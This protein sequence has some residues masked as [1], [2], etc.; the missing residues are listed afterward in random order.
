MSFRVTS[1][2]TVLAALILA[3]LVLIAL[4]TER[5]EALNLARLTAPGPVCKGQGSTSAPAKVQTKAML[6]LINYARKRSGIH[7]LK[8]SKRLD[9]SARRK[10][11]DMVRC[12]SFDHYACGRDFT[13]WMHKVGYTSRCWAGAENIAWGQH[14][15]GNP[16]QVF[17]SWMRSSGHRQNILSRNF[18]ALGVGLRKARFQGHRGAQLWTTHFG[19]RC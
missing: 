8:R 18:R 12:G 1:R 4:P 14:R 19:K 13:Y 7:R 17:R 5:A 2:T 16:R 9:R 3:L 10:S 11:S 15:L 6:C